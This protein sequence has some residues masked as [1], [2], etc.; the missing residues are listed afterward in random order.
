LPTLSE[1]LITNTCEPLCANAKSGFEIVDRE[2]PIPTNNFRF[3]ILSENQPEKTFKILAVVSATPSMSP[4]NALSTPSVTDKNTGSKGY[5]ISV[6][7]SVKKLT[8]PKMKTF[9]FNRIE[10]I[11]EMKYSVSIPFY[12]PLKVSLTTHI[13][14]DPIR[15][16]HT[17]RRGD[18][19]DGSYDR[20]SIDSRRNGESKKEWNL[21]VYIDGCGIF[22]LTYCKSE[23]RITGNEKF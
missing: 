5:I 7:K 10:N 17:T 20:S 22:V 1:N 16:C 15:V 23:D 12:K 14:T 6:E 13:P 18:R 19:M 21:F 11:M 8:N 9:F 2:Y 4:M 3:F